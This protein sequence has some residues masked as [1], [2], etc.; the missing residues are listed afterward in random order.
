MMCNGIDFPVLSLVQEVLLDA[1][2]DMVEAVL[3]PVLQHQGRAE[4][5]SGPALSAPADDSKQPDLQK[6][7][8]PPKSMGS[9][10]TSLSMRSELANPQANGSDA[11]SQCERS[12]LAKLSIS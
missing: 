9:F 6:L 12:H 8:I 1:D 7:S 4:C 10:M 5:Q 11:D 2:A 3:N